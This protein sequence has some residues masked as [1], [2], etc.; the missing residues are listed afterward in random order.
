MAGMRH[1]IWIALGAGAA[2]LVAAFAAP[3]WHMLRGPAPGLSPSPT[4]TR[5]LAGDDQNLPWQVRATGEGGSRVFGLHL[6][7]ARLTDAE[8]RFGD[9][10]QL[11]LV[12]RVGEVGTLEALVEPMSAGFVSGRL[13]LGFEVPAEVLARWRSNSREHS[14]MAGGVR[15]FRLEAAD[16][17]EA[18]RMPIA[19]M[20][21][22][23]SVRLGEADVRDRFGAPSAVQALPE[24]ALALL[25]PDRGLLVTVQPG[26]RGLL[27]YVPPALFEARLRAPLA[28]IAAS[29]AGAG[30]GAGS[31]AG[32]AGAASR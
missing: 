1:P 31:A 17:D 3:L 26:S 11:A 22:I 30:P 20:G 23:P 27:Q 7:Q 19:S 24:Q 8:A 21:F 9:V 16:R 2:V 10:L 18:R 29:A 14:A 32:A 25:Y 13:V 4:A 15:R 12:A 5:A 6:G 28:A